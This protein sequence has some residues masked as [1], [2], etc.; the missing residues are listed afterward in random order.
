MWTRDTQKNIGV[1]LQGGLG[2]QLFGWAAGKSLALS[3]GL[4]LELY[5]KNLSQRGFALEQLDPEALVLSQSP[6]R[7]LYQ[8]R[9]TFT[10][11]FFHFDERYTKIDKPILLNGYFQSWRYFFENHE[12]IKKII[13]D[14]EEK[15]TL[16]GFRADLMIHVRR[17]DYTKLTTYHGLI[18][19]MYYQRAIKLVKTMKSDPNIVVF[20]DD[21]ES[22]RR[23]VPG[24]TAY[25]GPEQ[26]LT[27]LE[28]LYCMTKCDHFIGANSSFSWWASYLNNG[29]GLK[30]FPRPWFT[31]K[32]NDT[33]DL[34]PPNWITL[35]NE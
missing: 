5:T 2:N 10:E 19:E 20:S 16:G 34:L 24:A 17:G 9:S 22:A 15:K 1:L 26:S 29:D 35:G 7:S 25:F 32:A 28:T 3:L 8:N 14:Y 21:I 11:R 30:I 27:P 12:E 31:D 4:D 18:G 6:N 33:R 23:V 13:Y